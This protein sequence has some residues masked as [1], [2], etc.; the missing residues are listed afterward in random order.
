MKV[1]VEG[2][3]PGTVTAI[4]PA[5]DP[6]NKQIEVHIAV[7]ATPDLVN[8]QSVRVTLPAETA[9]APT[10]GTATTTSAVLLPLTAVKLL[11]ESRAVFTVDAEGRVVAHTVTIGDVVGDRIEVLSGA[12]SDM[13]II[14]DVRGL[15]A[16]QKVQIAQD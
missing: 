5:L 10:S 12:S 2:N 11:P 3:H 4:A 16:G 13:R 6:T 7:D 15:S 8:G 1:S 14:T 9:V